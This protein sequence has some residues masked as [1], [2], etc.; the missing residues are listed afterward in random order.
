M[1]KKTSGKPR[2]ASAF[3]FWDSTIKWRKS[4]KKISKMYKTGAK[5]RIWDFFFKFL[6]K[7]FFISFE[8]CD[9][10]W[11]IPQQTWNNLANKNFERAIF[12]SCN[13]QTLCRKLEWNIGEIYKLVLSF[14]KT[15]IDNTAEI[16]FH[17]NALKNWCIIE[18]KYSSILKAR[19]LGAFTDPILPIK[20][21]YLL[22][23][24]NLI[25]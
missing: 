10:V 24:R 12:L 17:L 8:K 6:P 13:G 5:L 9:Y 7:K 20:C 19:S 1:K 22:S 15:N 25:G 21:R 11:G 18:S 14:T 2:I 16:I 23:T 3:K 4:N